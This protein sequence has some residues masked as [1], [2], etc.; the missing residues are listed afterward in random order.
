MLCSGTGKCTW[1]LAA[2]VLLLGLGLCMTNDRSIAMPC[3][4]YGFNPGSQLA[5]DSLDN[6]AVVGRAAVT[7]TL[8]GAAG[9]LS[10]LLT[11]YIRGKVQRR[12]SCALCV[13]IGRADV[14]G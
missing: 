4:R 1:A 6:A 11:A 10:C 2:R 9:C 14:A 13:H 8:S 3:F 12:P 7:T 5:I